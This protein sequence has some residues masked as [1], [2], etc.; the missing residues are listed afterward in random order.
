MRKQ[1]NYADYIF[2]KKILYIYHDGKLVETKELWIDDFFDEVD[3]LEY[4]GYV[5]GYTKELVEEAKRQY[6]RMLANIIEVC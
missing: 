5:L 6:E 4:D 1:Y 2:G 3:K